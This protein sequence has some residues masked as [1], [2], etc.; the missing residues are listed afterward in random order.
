MQM[1]LELDVIDDGSNFKQGS[2]IPVIENISI[3]LT[4][5]YVLVFDAADGPDRI[6][7]TKTEIGFG[8]SL[9]CRIG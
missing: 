2:L 1:A 6:L 7:R 9:S 5:Q 4:D 3:P 8:N